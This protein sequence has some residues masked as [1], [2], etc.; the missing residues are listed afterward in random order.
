MG[1]SHHKFVTR[2]MGYKQALPVIR[3]QVVPL[4]RKAS[5][6]CDRKI[7]ADPFYG[8]RVDD[9][10]QFIESWF[11]SHNHTVVVK[12]SREVVLQREVEQLKEEVAL[13][14]RECT[15]LREVVA[16]KTKG[17]ELL[18]KMLK[19]KPENVVKEQ[20]VESLLQQFKLTYCVL[21]LANSI[22]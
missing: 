3:D 13:K 18:E 4:L 9:L 21:R 2:K 17:I 1:Y 6:N 19:L 14:T 20:T 16:F 5:S 12:Q 22:F 10:V 7:Y 11:A 8:K 15:S